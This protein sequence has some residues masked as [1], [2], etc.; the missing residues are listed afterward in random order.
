MRHHDKPRVRE[1][2]VEC[3]PKLKD[4]GDIQHDRS[5]LTETAVSRTRR[6]P[7][8]LDNAFES[9]GRWVERPAGMARIQVGN[10]GV[11]HGVARV[12]DETSNQCVTEPSKAMEPRDDE[13]GHLAKAMG[14][15]TLRAG[16]QR[17]GPGKL[18][19]IFTHSISGA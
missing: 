9:V 17:S 5:V 18:Y 16:G 4:H 12:V 3:W 14:S 15:V 8:G 6:D 1:Q 10:L 13:H 19:H 7:P 2:E 11:H